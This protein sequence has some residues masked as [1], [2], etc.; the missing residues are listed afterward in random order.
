MTQPRLPPGSRLCDLT[1]RRGRRTGAPRPGPWVAV[2]KVSLGL[3]RG[4]M[5]IVEQQ[6]AKVAAWRVQGWH[7]RGLGQPRLFAGRHDRGR[8]ARQ[9]PWCLVRVMVD[10][11]WEDG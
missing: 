6:A 1:G 5:A 8:G 7:L 4:Q 3:L 2:Q 10:A 11:E 9:T